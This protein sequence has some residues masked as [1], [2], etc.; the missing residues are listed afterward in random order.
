MSG[1]RQPACP[2]SWQGRFPEAGYPFTRSSNWA[3]APLARKLS[4][5]SPARSLVLA[6]PRAD[7]SWKLEARLAQAGFAFGAL[8][9]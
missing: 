3:A 5:A 6:P 7:N 2:R 1:A 8:G 4:N 9:E